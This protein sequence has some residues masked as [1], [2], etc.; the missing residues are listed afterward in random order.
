MGNETGG[1]R[2]RDRR[3]RKGRG[4][5]N[6]RWRMA[7]LAQFHKFD[8]P[9]KRFN[10]AKDRVKK[11]WTCGNGVLVREESTTEKVVWKTA[12]GRVSSWTRTPPEGPVYFDPPPAPAHAEEQEGYPP[13]MQHHSMHANGPEYYYPDSMGGGMTEWK[14]LN[15]QANEDDPQAQSGSASMVGA[16]TEATEEKV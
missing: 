6:D 13:W 15:Y 10:I 16:S 3:R 2:Q 5:G 11:R 14:E 8:L 4:K 9:D 12:D 1:G 7:F